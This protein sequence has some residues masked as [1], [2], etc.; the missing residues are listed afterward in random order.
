MTR[1]TYISLVF[2]Q[3]HNFD[4]IVLEGWLQ[5]IAS[6]HVS[7]ALEFVKLLA[8]KLQDLGKEFILVVPPIRG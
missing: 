1:F 6:G 7:P 2:L 4:G 8:L 5:L 3:K